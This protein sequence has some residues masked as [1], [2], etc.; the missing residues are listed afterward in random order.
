MSPRAKCHPRSHLKSGLAE[1]CQGKMSQG[2]M[3]Q[4]NMSPRAK[5]LRAECH[6]TEL[7]QSTQKSM[8]PIQINLINQ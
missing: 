1:K 7:G 3:S 6:P 8:K 5:R 4:G 2:N